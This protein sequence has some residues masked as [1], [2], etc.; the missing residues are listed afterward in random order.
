M[1]NNT[2]GTD[3]P[4]CVRKYQDIP[5][6]DMLECLSFME[7]DKKALVNMPNSKK[8]LSKLF[9]FVAGEPKLHVLPCR[10]KKDLWNSIS[11]RYVARGRPADHVNLAPGM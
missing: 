6:K 2:S 10:K 9:L 5:V 1:A 8:D 4:R 7:F 3:F 11:Q